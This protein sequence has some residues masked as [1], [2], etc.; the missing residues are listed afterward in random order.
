MNHDGSDS[1]SALLLNNEYIW[2]CE[3]VIKWVSEAAIDKSIQSGPNSVLIA[4][5]VWIWQS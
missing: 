2:N 3:G 5:E 1:D 4:G